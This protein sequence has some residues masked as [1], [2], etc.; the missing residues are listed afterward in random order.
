MAKVKKRF[1]RVAARNHSIPADEGMQFLDAVEEGN[2]A[3][4]ELFIDKYGP[5]ILEV[6]ARDWMPSGKVSI[7]SNSQTALFYAVD[8]E[9]A[10]MVEMLIGKGAD[11]NAR[12]DE[13]H[14]I[15]ML[16]RSNAMTELL[17]KKGA[18]L[19]ATNDDGWTAL[20]WPQTPDGLKFL[21]EHG[22]D[23]HARDNSG[24]T[25]FLRVADGHYVHK[26]RPPQEHLEVL[27]DAKS[28]IE[29]QDKEGRTALILAAAQSAYADEA[30]DVVAFL[31]KRGANPDARDNTGKTAAMYARISRPDLDANEAQQKAV[32]EM[33]DQ[34]TERRAATLRKLIVEGG[35]TN[36]AIFKP[37]QFK[38]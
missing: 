15:L 22:A 9:M 3:L 13:G 16:A 28:D 26:D 34:E 27:L 14:T 10:E 8:A 7:E 6:R 25:A 11:L 2:I 36:I 17:L 12:M 18:Q 23:V 31:L 21:L 20:M 35:D 37:L 19:E 4:A 38:K 33:L 32:A 29:A 24:K 1:N 5:E 30:L